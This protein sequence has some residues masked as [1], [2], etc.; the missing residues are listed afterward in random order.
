EF[1]FAL[2]PGAAGLADADAAEDIEALV[3]RR[4]LRVVGERFD[5]VHDQ[6]REVVYGQLL[7]PR[8]TLLHAAVVQAIERLHAGRL[9]EHVEQLAH[10]ALRGEVWDKAVLHGR[11]AGDVAA[12]RSA[13]AQ[14]AAYFAQAIQALARRPDDPEALEQGIELRE[15]LTAHLFALGQRAAYLESM[16][17]AVALAERLGDPRWL[18]RVL[19][20]RSNALWFAGDS[21]RALES[22]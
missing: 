7:P 3:R 2:L 16:T 5:F 8:R 9:D 13:S 15:L 22:A 18:A 6:V 21:R 14:A 20:L 10:H 12:E 19:S 4:F 17:E 1:D 11:R